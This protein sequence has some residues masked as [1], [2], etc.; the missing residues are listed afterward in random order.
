[1]IRS[2][3]LMSAGNKCRETSPCSFLILQGGLRPRTGFPFLLSPESRRASSASPLGS[4][5]AILVAHASH[6]GRVAAKRFRKRS[7]QVLFLVAGTPHGGRKRPRCCSEAE[8]LFSPL[9]LLTAASGGR[10]F[11]V[12]KGPVL[13]D[14]VEVRTKR[15]R[16]RSIS[17]R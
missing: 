8:L 1:M 16:W 4:K 10:A 6:G 13:V 14:K 3:V 7:A 5:H 2:E 11:K 17:R 15:P 12:D 9:K